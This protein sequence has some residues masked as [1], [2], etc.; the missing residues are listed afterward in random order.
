MCNGTYLKI[1]KG[2]RVLSL[3]SCTWQDFHCEYNSQV[4]SLVYM[5]LSQ[6]FH[7]DCVH[8]HAKLVV[9]AV[10]G[11]VVWLDSHCDSGEGYVGAHAEHVE[12]LSLGC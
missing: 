12:L 5:T 8:H 3:H 9:V 11:A 7:F 10:A 2:P 6:D 1:A 4:P